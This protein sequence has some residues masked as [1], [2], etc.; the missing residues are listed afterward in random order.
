MNLLE[1][2]EFCQA[3]VCSCGFFRRAGSPALRQARMPAATVAGEASFRWE[4]GL[5]RDENA[6]FAHANETGRTQNV[7]ARKQ[8][9][10]FCRRNDAGR[11]QNA[12]FRWRNEAFPAQNETGFWQPVRRW[13]GTAR[14]CPRVPRPETT[15]ER[16]LPQ[17]AAAPP[18][19][20]LI[21][22][23]FR[24]A[25][26]LPNPNR[27]RNPN[28]LQTTIKIKNKIKIRAASLGCLR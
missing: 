17:C 21:G 14:P 23:W 1:I 15:L 11:E 9:A 24:A 8:N 28:P 3:R 20:I 5:T 12:S 13:T 18:G 27:H 10:S 19:R 4:N 26:Q 6:S 25:R 22:I 7:A 16:N 2:S